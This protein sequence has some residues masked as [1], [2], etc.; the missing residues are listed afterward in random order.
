MCHVWDDQPIPKRQVNVVARPLSR[1]CFTLQVLSQ[2]PTNFASLRRNGDCHAEWQHEGWQPQVPGRRRMA[3]VARLPL[4]DW[5]HNTIQICFGTCVAT[6]QL[7]ISQTAVSKPPVDV[8]LHLCEH[9]SSQRGAM[10]PFRSAAARPVLAAARSRR[11]LQCRAGNLLVE[12]LGSGVG[13]AAVTAVTTFTS[14][15]RDA[16]IERLQASESA[17]HRTTFGHSPETRRPADNQI[18]NT[19]QLHQVPVRAACNK[20][21]RVQAAADPQCM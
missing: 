12:I 16:E 9:N 17:P 1:R 5:Y 6:S 15:N 8:L 3:P 20:V 13:A 7:S 4:W 10:Q 21:S 11:A 19:S 2:R 18:P 14:E